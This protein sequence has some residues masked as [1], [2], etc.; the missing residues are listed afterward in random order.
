MVLLA[1]TGATHM[2][3]LSLTT[4]A[5]SVSTSSQ[6]KNNQICKTWT[7]RMAPKIVRLTIRS[8]LSTNDW[9][10]R[11]NTTL[12]SHFTPQTCNQLIIWALQMVVAFKQRRS[13]KLDLY[14]ART[15]KSASSWKNCSI[16]SRRLST[17]VRL[18]IQMKMLLR[19]RLE[20]EK[21]ISLKNVIL[22]SNALKSKFNY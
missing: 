16:L 9:P 3:D 1:C 11:R 6:A 4:S 14:R 5:N 19:E 21:E 10:R 2:K 8:T 22:S 17:C 7:C 15:S 18:L 13:E 12:P 20:I